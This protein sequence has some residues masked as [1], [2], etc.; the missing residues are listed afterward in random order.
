MHNTGNNFI[1][2]NY[3]ENEKFYN[4]RIVCMYCVDYKTEFLMVN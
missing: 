2:E 4:T 3:L 1:T